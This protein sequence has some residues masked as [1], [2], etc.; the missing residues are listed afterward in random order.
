MITGYRIEQSANGT[1]WTTLVSDTGSTATT[2]TVT[3]LNNGQTYLLRV[4]PLSAVGTGAAS[5]GVAV[6]PRGGAAAPTA[7]TV[8]TGSRSAVL[9]W[10]APVSDG[11]S[12][13]TGYRI[14]VSSNGGSSFTT[15]VANTGSSATSHSIAGLVNGTPLLVKVAAI[16]SFGVGAESV[17]SESF[18]PAAPSTAP[19]SLSVLGGNASA[20]VSWSA[21]ASTNGAS[22]V[23]YTVETSVDGGSTWIVVSTSA[24]SPHTLSSLTNGVTHLVR[25]TA[26]NAAGTSAPSSA[27]VVTPAGVPGT[28]VGLTILSGNGLL[29]MTW[30]APGNSGGLPVTSYIVQTSSDGNVWTTASSGSPASSAVLTGLAN[31]VPVHVR[32][33]AVNAAGSGAYTTSVIATPSVGAL[34]GLPTNLVATPGNGQVALSWNAPVVSGGTPVT[35]Y[36]VSQS[37]DGTNWSII[38]SGT[39]TAVTSYLATGLTNGVP[40]SFRVSANNGA[41]TGPES[42][43]ASATPRTVAT[44]P[45][46][47]SVTPG[48]GQASLAWSAPASNGGATV[49]A[50]IVESSTDGG[51]TWTV[52]TTTTSLTHVVTGLVNGTSYAFHVSAVNAAGTGVA[53]RS[54]MATPFSTSGAVGGLNAVAGD[55]QAVVTWSAPT[56]NGGSAVSGYGVAVSN[57]GGQTFGTE[58]TV[59]G[60]NAVVTGLVNGTQSIVRVVP[61]TA[62]GRGTASTVN[63]TPRALP[64]SPV[65]LSAIASNGQVALSWTAP[66]DNG[67]SAIISYAIERAPVNGGAWVRIDTTPSLSYTSGGLVNGTAYSFRIVATNAAGDGAASATVNATPATTPSAPQ[68]VTTVISDSSITVSWLAPVSSGGSVVT[69]YVVETTTDGSTWISGVTTTSTVATVSGLVNGTSY[70]VRV[71]AINIV[72]T[73]TASTTATATPSGTPSAP[74]ALTPVAGNRQI[75][76]SWT[77]PSSNGGAGIVDYVVESSANGGVAWRSVGTVTAPSTATVITGL[78]NGVAYVFRVT[79]RNVAGTGAASTWVTAAPVAPPRAPLSVAATTVEATPT[80]STATAAVAWVP[81]TDDGGAA[82]AGYR[83]QTSTDGGLTWGSTVQ[84][85]PDPIATDPFEGLS[86]QESDSERSARGTVAEQRLNRMAVVTNDDGLVGSTLLTFDGLT[87]GVTY[88]FRVQAY[89]VIGDS[90][91]QSTSLTPE[92]PVFPPTNPAAVIDS[93]FVPVVAGLQILWSPAASGATATA[94]VVERQRPNGTW[95]VVSVTTGTSV[96]DSNATLGNTYTYRI[97]PYN[98]LLAGESVL[99]TNARVPANPNPTISV[100]LGASGEPTTTRFTV[101]AKDLSPRSRA[102]IVLETSDGTVLSTLSNPSVPSNGRLASTSRIPRDLAP[103]RYVVRLIATD[104]YGQTVETTSTFDVTATWNPIDAVSPTP[105]GAIPPPTFGRG[106]DGGLDIRWERPSSGPTPTSFVIERQRPDGTWEV[107]S[108]AVESPFSDMS[109]ILGETYTYR[110]TP[111]NGTTP[112]EAT[113]I[114]NVRIPA[115]PRLASDLLFDGRGQPKKVNFAWTGRDLRPGSEA[116]VR[117]ESSDGSTIIELGRVVIGPDGSLDAK[118]ILPRD[119]APGSYRLIIEATDAYG[120]DTDVRYE[121]DISEDWAPSD[122]PDPNDGDGSENSGD[123]SDGDGGMS[124]MWRIFIYVGVIALLFGAIAVAGWWYII[125]R[126]RDEDEDEE[127]DKIESDT[128]P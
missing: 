62:G 59:T 102:R 35:G 52:E 37:F 105:P 93:R 78:T 123:S 67:G 128:R 109:A 12:S 11:G 23:G 89:T 16:T 4:V 81:P 9:S 45:L 70:G 31:G 121:F 94:Y 10:T 43:P 51:T 77:A 3:S 28:P 40:V 111:Y 46:D 115:D 74:T 39:G 65:T 6:T 113:V 97:T 29:S 13:I 15:L 19:Q 69:S 106:V 1:T 88:R 73:G 72:G 101:G 80:S 107:I 42:A 48:N 26:Q 98:G 8:V 64:G 30:S 27:A 99:V 22:V 126:R 25:V 127:Q 58:R 5:T 91:W 33:A 41:G 50:Y 54:V 32:V 122:A 17:A 95:E 57:D 7:P 79:A 66:I 87:F 47:L 124:T 125:A 38:T 36:V 117:V 86:I 116:T 83:I 53:T 2:T 49:T 84:L 96:V 34:A 20:T 21:P 108:I 90:E 103:G 104:V 14:L 63:V 92:R 55:G 60:T 110:I 44:T 75:S 82:V 18:T 76:L 100:R 118:A 112:G 71:R 114:E 119:L 61:I 85:G 120:D 56:N 24:T 68:N